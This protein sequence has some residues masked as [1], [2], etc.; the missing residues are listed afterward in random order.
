[1]PEHKVTTGP[2]YCMEFPDDID[3][4]LLAEI[5]QDI[6][7]KNHI[8]TKFERKVMEQIETAETDQC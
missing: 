8:E 6:S 5:N 4:V 7:A 2:N 1:M 3:P